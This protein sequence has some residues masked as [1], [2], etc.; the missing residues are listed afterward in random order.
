[1]ARNIIKPHIYSQNI[2]RRLKLVH[3]TLRWL[4]NMPVSR[5]ILHKLQHVGNP[6]LKCTVF[7]INFPNPIGIAAGFDT[8]GRLFNG[9]A[10]VGAGFVEI[11]TV[12]DKPQAGSPKPR[13]FKIPAD[14]ALINRMGH[15]N[16]G[17][18]EVIKNI[19]ENQPARIP[20]FG[21]IGRNF[22]SGQERAV[23][24]IDNLYTMMY[25]FV[26]A[27]V[28]NTAGLRPETLQQV[29]ERIT[30]IR[31]F[32]DEY[33]PVLLKT[34]P[35]CSD[36]EVAAMVETVL[37]NGLDG[38]VVCGTTLS[39]RGL[40]TKQQVLDKI[41]NGELSGAPVFENTRR[42]LRLVLEK[43]RSIVPVVVTGGIMSPEQAA[44][45]LDEGASLV[46]IHT[47]LVYGG[48]KFIRRIK[49]HLLDREKSR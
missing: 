39:H 24:D 15:S 41:G 32:N 44:T 2:E 34:R 19:R 17:V 9:L 21:N 3:R 22:D 6:S 13:Y 26:D 11:G 45:L 27:V 49:R 29:V 14:R 8:S 4:K 46:E 12:T 47:G 31:R 10:S 1:M 28:I 48:H 38:I 43:G 42:L 30:G 36:D 16:P 37:E 35:D 18:R 20:V 5:A 25:D 7:G 40:L 33:R 23:E